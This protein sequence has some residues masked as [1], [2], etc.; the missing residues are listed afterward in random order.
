MKQVDSVS[1][2][3][4]AVSYTNLNLTR[5]LLKILKHF[6]KYFKPLLFKHLECQV[7]FENY[8]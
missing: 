2:S 5:E 7:I 4:S 1:D 6:A 3:F 8:I